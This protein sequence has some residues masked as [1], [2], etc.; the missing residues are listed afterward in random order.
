MKPYRVTIQSKLVAVLSFGILNCKK[1]NENM[2]YFELD[3]L[4]CS[5]Q[6]S[7]SVPCGFSTVTN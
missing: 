7:N 3:N 1:E 4:E 5:C 2:I 6:L